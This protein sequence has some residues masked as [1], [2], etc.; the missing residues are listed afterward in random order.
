[1]KNVYKPQY[2][3]YYWKIGIGEIGEY[4]WDDDFSD[5]LLYSIGNCFPYTEEGKKQCEE[6]GKKYA[7]AFI[8]LMN[9]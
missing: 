9:R 3:Y 6:W 4:M 5:I 8:Y 1:M 2:N 7:P